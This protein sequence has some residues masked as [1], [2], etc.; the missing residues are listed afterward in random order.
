[1]KHIAK[2]SLLAAFKNILYGFII[3]AVMLIPGVSGGTTAIILGI[4]DQLIAAVAEF[5]KDM[6]K[7]GLFLLT[8]AVGG[9][10]GL[11]LC[12]KLLLM[13]VELWE[14]PMLCLF[15]GAI[16][17]SFP[18]LVRKSRGGF[19]FVSVLFLLIGFGLALATA[20]VPK[21][22]V[23]VEGHSFRTFCILF[24]LGL[25]LAVALVLPGISFSS[26]L[27]VFSI[28]EKFMASLQ[29]AT[30]DF[31]FLLPLGLGLVAGILLT[32]KLLE[33]A[34]SKYPGPTYFAIIGFVLGSVL[35]IFSSM[36]HVPSG[37]EIPAG[38]LLFAAGAVGVWVYARNAE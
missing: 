10:L 7:N 2:P 24:L 36:P 6:W 4:Y 32:T 28:H 14:V 30:F 18:L 19:N 33:K 12:S 38:I 8:V 15:A 23:A 27:A 1:M 5:F 16:A 13:L 17:G 9:L 3:G 11:V 25:P 26:I 31:W 20:L 21:D 22:L 35:E 34:M 37:L 29:P